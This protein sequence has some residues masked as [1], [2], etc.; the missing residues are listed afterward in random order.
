MKPKMVHAVYILSKRKRGT[1][2]AGVTQDLRRRVWEHKQ[3][4]SSFTRRYGVHRPVYYEIYEDADAAL[5]RERQ[6]KRRRRSRK[7][8]LIEQTN[9]QW[10]DPFSTLI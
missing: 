7:V 2:Y 1:I 6:L 9:P 5:L 3:G 10:E 4:L 8:E